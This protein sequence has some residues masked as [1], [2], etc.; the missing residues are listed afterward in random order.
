M[1]LLL[2]ILAGLG[3]EYHPVN[4]LYHISHMRSIYASCQILQEDVDMALKRLKTL[5]SACIQL[6]YSLEEKLDMI[7]RFDRKRIGEIPQAI[8]KESLLKK[9]S[10]CKTKMQL[11]SIHTSTSG[12]IQGLPS[13]ELLSA[14]NAIFSSV[15]QARYGINVDHTA[16]QDG[17]E[18][19]IEALK[20]APRKIQF[21]LIQYRHTIENRNMALY[22]SGTG[23]VDLCKESLRYLRQQLHLPESEKALIGRL[24]FIKRVMVHSALSA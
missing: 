12:F 19:M 18:K 23:L 10:E 3:E 17:N 22:G 7:Q 15:R 11:S 14:I 24:V 4:P 9:L 8:D 5:M 1:K 2:E 6:I 21:A 20:D 16:Y 13:P